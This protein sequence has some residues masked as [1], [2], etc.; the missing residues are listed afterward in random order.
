L[1]LAFSLVFWTFALTGMHESSVSCLLNI[2]MHR[3]PACF[4]KKN[5]PYPSR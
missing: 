4:R 3:S 2:T 5:R 1:F